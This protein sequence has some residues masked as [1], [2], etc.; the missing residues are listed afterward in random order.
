MPRFRRKCVGKMKDVAGEGRTVLFVSHN[1]QAVRTLCLSAVVLDSGRLAF[2]GACSDCV[3]T[4]ESVSLD[5]R[6]SEWRCTDKSDKRPLAFEAASCGIFGRQPDLLLRIDLTL[7]SNR[8]HAPAFLAV[9]ILESGG[10]A[11]M[12]AIPCLDPFIRPSFQSHRLV[13][14]INLPPL[15]PGTYGLTF[16]VGP[17]NT[18]TFDE[19]PNCAEFEVLESPAIGRT[20]PHHRSH[21]LLV[22]SSR[23]DT[24]KCKTKQLR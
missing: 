20:F 22:P 9:D 11:L 12:Q 3:T 1:M 8:Q 24:P 4:Y 7:R 21:G 17:H 2:S 6:R 18:E 13:I 14:T 10:S 19:V 16:W 15:V 23:V 5:Q